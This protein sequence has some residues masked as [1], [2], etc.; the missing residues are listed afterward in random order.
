MDNHLAEYHYPLSIC[1][2]PGNRELISASVLAVAQMC[3]SPKIRLNWIFHNRQNKAFLHSVGP[4]FKTYSIAAD[5]SLPQEKWQDVIQSQMD[6]QMV[7]SRYDYGFCGETEKPFVSDAIE[8]NC[9]LPLFDQQIST[10]RIMTPVFTPQTNLA[11]NIRMDV[12]IITIAGKYELSIQYM[13]PLYDEASVRQL[14]Q[15]IDQFL[16]S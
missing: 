3:E 16:Q 15:R 14:C 8:I 13:T 9:L 1:R 7:Y 11:T 12:E 2:A 5:T 10:G 6:K 4:F